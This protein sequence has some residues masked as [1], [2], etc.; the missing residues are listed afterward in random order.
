M[1]AENTSLD[2][3]F[4]KINETRKYLLEEIKHNEL[5]E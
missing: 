5:I 1:G 4:K 2:F 3:S